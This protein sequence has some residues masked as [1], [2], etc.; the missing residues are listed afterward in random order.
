MTLTCRNCQITVKP[1]SARGASYNVGDVVK[2]TG[3]SMV[4]CNNQSE[5]IWLCYVCAGIASTH[6]KALHRMTGSFN[7]GFS[8]LITLAGDNGANS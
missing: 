5:L 7:L 1:K 2:E 6:A 4:V 3:W 8:Q